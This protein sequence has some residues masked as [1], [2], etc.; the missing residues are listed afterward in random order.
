MWIK[1]DQLKVDACSAPVP[2]EKALPAALR[3]TLGV[4]VRDYVIA[5][6]SVDARRRDDIRLDFQPDY[7][8]YCVVRFP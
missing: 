3:K 5:G 8:I 2:P 4:P 7:K 6:K 1:I